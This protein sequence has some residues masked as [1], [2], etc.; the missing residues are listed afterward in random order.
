L[1]IIRPFFSKTAVLSHFFSK[2]RIFGYKTNSGKGTSKT[3]VGKLIGKKSHTRYKIVSRTFIELYISAV[4][5]ESL[6]ILEECSIKLFRLQILAGKYF[7][8]KS[9][10]LSNLI[11]CVE[12]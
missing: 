2:K 10:L 3:F 12:N 6:G 5:E 4:R 1:P 11:F 9:K 8:R 7:A